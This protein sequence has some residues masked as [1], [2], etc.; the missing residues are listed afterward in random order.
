MVVDLSEFRNDD[1]VLPGTN[2]QLTTRITHACRQAGFEPV[3]AYHAASLHTLK[4]LVRAGLGV[5]VLPNCA[6]TGPG[7]GDLSVLR[8]KG[9]LTRELH[10]VKA[11]DRDLTPAAQVLLT[12]MRTEVA[13]AMTYPPKP[14]RVVPEQPAM[15]VPAPSLAAI[16]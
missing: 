2:F 16:D 6:L 9:G 15:P 13:T 12:H 14:K 4:N 7:R 5:S 11:K 8:I 10:L 3:V 1:F